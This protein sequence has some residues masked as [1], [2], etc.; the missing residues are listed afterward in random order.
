MRQTLLCITHVATHIYQQWLAG[1]QQMWAWLRWVD[2]NLSFCHDVLLG[3]LLIVAYMHD[4]MA[5]PES[6]MVSYMV[7]F[8]LFTCYCTHKK[9]RQAPSLTLTFS[10]TM[11]CLLQI[12]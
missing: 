8:M 4:H 6:V 11:C 7:I 1:D 10:P 2:S 12:G 9:V 3:V 5:L